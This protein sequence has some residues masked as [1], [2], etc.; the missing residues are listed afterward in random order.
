MRSEI[1]KLDVVTAIADAEHEDYVSELLYSQGWNILFR[2][3]EA[4]SLQRFLLTRAELRTVL[5]F[6][7]D[8]MG[9]SSEIFSALDLRNLT[10]ISLDGIP[11]NAHAIMTHI[12]QELRTPLLTPA[13]SAIIRQQ[14]AP[15]FMPSL[16]S[17]SRT[18]ITKR[19]KVISITGSGGAPGRT[20]FA[21]ALAHELSMLE[22]ILLV[23]A[24]LRSQGLVRLV[25]YLESRTNYSSTNF[26]KKYANLERSSTAR[27]DSAQK[28]KS[29][30]KAHAS[31]YRARSIQLAP[32]D[33][34]ER[35][36]ILPD[37]ERTAVVDLGT[38]PALSEVV[39][40]RRWQGSLVN[41]ILES[42]SNLVYIV[43]STAS[44]IEEL[45]IFMRDFPVLLK[46]IPITYLCVLAGHSRSLRE[47][48]S[49]FLTLTLGENRHIVRGSQLD[50]TQES[51]LFPFLRQGDSTNKEIAK[52]LA[53]LH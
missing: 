29:Q 28:G 50:L 5:I 22:P 48:E 17:Q 39:T 36:T 15:T 25:S 27:L 45:S 47:W 9:Y 41:N 3:S 12:R 31:S 1:P 21:L 43:K 7:S 34:V 52:I 32:L 33:P 13:Q 26:S 38:L 14:N 37:G 40:D 16:P 2:A 19:R 18:E 20:R 49:N 53:S 30:R 42:T 8:L 11:E 51:S 23:D 35:P 46:N 24:D 10:L 4:L 6:R 44:S